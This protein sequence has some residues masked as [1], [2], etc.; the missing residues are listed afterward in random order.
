MSWSVTCLSLL[1]DEL[2][3]KEKTKGLVREGDNEWPRGTTLR[4][5]S[6]RRATTSGRAATEGD[7]ERSRRNGGRQRAALWRNLEERLTMSDAGQVKVGGL[8]ARTE[9][10]LQAPWEAATE[11]LE[12]V[13]EFEDLTAANL[14]GVNLETLKEAKDLT[15]AI[16]TGANLVL[17]SHTRKSWRGTRRRTW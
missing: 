16:L 12:E 9:E 7:S 10:K 11:T 17:Q 3:L 1:E 5:G 4:S 13:E 8:L 15:A 2:W 14:M 6:R